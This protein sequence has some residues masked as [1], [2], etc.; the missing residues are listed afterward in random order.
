[1]AIFLRTYVIQP[2][3][4]GTVFIDEKLFPKRLEFCNMFKKYSLLNLCFYS[5]F[6]VLFYV[7][8]SI[9]S[10]VSNQDKYKK[11]YTETLENITK[12]KSE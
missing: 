4:S 8:R 11:L 7:D 6:F 1:M 2:L 12:S 9:L 10:G 3:I 5:S